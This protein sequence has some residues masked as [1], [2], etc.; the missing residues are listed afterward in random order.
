MLPHDGRIGRSVGSGCT[1]GRR[2]S[3][4]RQPRG[5]GSTRDAR[6]ARKQP[7][8]MGRSH[9]VRR[10]TLNTLAIKQALGEGKVVVGTWV[11]EFNTPGIARLLA[12]TGVDFVVYD[13]E[14]SGFGIE[15]IRNLVAGTRPL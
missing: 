15:T 12:S 7:R 11:F 9:L 8:Q 10:T 13:M 5:P 6:E 4:R 14:H 1:Q 2:A 3:I